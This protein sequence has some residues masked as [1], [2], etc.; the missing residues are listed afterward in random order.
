M[1]EHSNLIPANAWDSG[2]DISCKDRSNS[3]AW[4]DCFANQS[5]GMCSRH[6]LNAWA[7]SR[8]TFLKD[9]N[10]LSEGMRT[11]ETLIN[12]Y[13]EHCREEPKLPTE[14]AK[15]PANWWNELVTAFD[16]AHREEIIAFWC[17]EKP[18]GADAQKAWHD[19]RADVQHAR[20]LYQMSFE[21]IPPLLVLHTQL[22]ENSEG[23][24]K[25][26]MESGHDS[27]DQ[28]D[29][30]SLSKHTK[31]RSVNSQAPPLAGTGL[32]RQYQIFAALNVLAGMLGISAAAAPAVLRRW[33]WETGTAT[34]MQYTR[35]RSGV[36]M[37]LAFSA[38]YMVTNS[39]QPTGIAVYKRI[40]PGTGHWSIDEHVCLLC[41][42]ILAVSFAIGYTAA[43]EGTQGLRQVFDPKSWV[44][45][46][47][48]SVL[49]IIFEVL[50]FQAFGLMSISSV[51]MYI[52]T[53]LVPVAVGRC[54]LFKQRYSAGS[55]LALVTVCI[56][57]MAFVSTDALTTRAGLAHV[58]LAVTVSA[59]ASLSG[60]HLLKADSKTSAIVQFLWTMPAEILPL[61][62]QL[63]LHQHSDQS[64]LW[65]QGAFAPFHHFN[66][67]AWFVAAGMGA[68]CLFSIMFVKSYDSLTKTVA[69][70]C[71]IVFPTWVSLFLMG[72]EHLWSPSQALCGLM[73]LISCIGFAYLQHN[74]RTPTMN[75]SYGSLAAAAQNMAGFKA[76]P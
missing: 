42:R 49:Y 46:S 54:L 28:E 22:L 66:L 44:L 58:L 45:Y 12:S 75:T 1:L 67:V 76:V 13:A 33:H 56:S 74:D 61:A 37:T 6:P 50:K 10:S 52:Q 9:D 5:A 53:V 27:L 30:A 24:F 51:Q 17:L 34:R 71:S 23:P 40:S 65:V 31:L 26:D 47:I 68:H 72:E 20:N 7:L 64:N 15:T 39:L 57:S 41:S 14:T 18:S 43:S 38:L 4:T 35:Q 70:I 69:G 2:R 19:A 3:F 73:V 48:P 16:V 25:I 55:V 59:A 32:H 29:V 62:V 11:S 63:A 36:S 21:Q 8:C 60:E